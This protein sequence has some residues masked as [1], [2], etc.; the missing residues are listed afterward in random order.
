MP[1]IYL[2]HRFSQLFFC[3]YSLNYFIIREIF[4]VD[5]VHTV[6]QYFMFV[7]KYFV[8]ICD[9]KYTTVLNAAR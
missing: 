4:E 2:L 8:Q 1:A 9:L 7:F 6:T 5:K 3:S